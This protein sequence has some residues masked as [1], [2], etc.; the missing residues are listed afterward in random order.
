VRIDNSEMLALLNDTAP[1]RPG[2]NDLIEYD[3]S[4]ANFRLL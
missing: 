1:G 4:H 2:G 3:A